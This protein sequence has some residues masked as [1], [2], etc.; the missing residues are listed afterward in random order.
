MKQT[1]EKKG[2]PY[3]VVLHDQS[4]T[5][6]AHHYSVDRKPWTRYYYRLMTAWY[7]FI[8]PSNARVLHVGCEDGSLLKAVQPSVGVGV[9]ENAR[10]RIQ[11][12]QRYSG[13]SYYQNLDEVPVMTFDYIVLSSTTMEVD[14]VQELFTKLHAFSHKRTRVVVES[15]HH[16]WEP[17]LRLATRLGLRRP[18]ELK[19]WFSYYDL[20]NVLELAGWQ[21]ITRKKQVLFPLYVPIV[22]WFLNTV[23]APLPGINRLCLS[24]MVVARPVPGIGEAQAVTV[25]VIIPCKNERGTIKDALVRTPN[26]GAHT[27]L[28]FVDGHSVDGTYEYMSQV[29]LEYPDRDI[30]VLRQAGKGKADAV[31][32]GF[33]KAKGDVLMILDG[34]LTMPPEELPKFFDALVSGRGEFINGSRLVY[35]R[36]AGEMIFL[37][38]LANYWFGMAFTWLLDQRIKDTLC[39]TKVLFKEDYEQIARNR[40]YFGDFDPFGD[41]DLLFG[42][43][44]LNLKIVDMPIHYKK[45][46][47][48]SP[49]VNKFKTVWLLLGMCLFAFKNFKRI[50]Q[51]VF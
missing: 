30:T 50:R 34:D 11:A 44:K 4:I 35:N 27:E 5:H 32:L 9:E 25:S 17:V 43:A 45:R 6:Q 37:A 38:M 28:I 7:Q 13:F 31:R 49:Q 14:D 36:E 8:I 20:A 33:S 26:M 10:M 41:F 29:A 46:V 18:A 21:V 22:S 12:Q 48:G 42:A 3:Q 40:S 2:A 15:Y 47:Y 19:N 39:G 1:H 51:S 23:L 24:Q 16:L